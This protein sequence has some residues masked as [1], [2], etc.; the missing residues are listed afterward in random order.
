[1]TI[2]SPSEDLRNWVV[3]NWFAVEDS[4]G[5][6]LQTMIVDSKPLTSQGNKKELYEVRH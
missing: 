5:L 3:D 2:L 4:I 6:A 1:M